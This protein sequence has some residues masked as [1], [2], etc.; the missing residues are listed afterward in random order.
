MSIS[1]HTSEESHEGTE[2]LLDIVLPEATPANEEHYE[3]ELPHDFDWR[4]HVGDPDLVPSELAEKLDEFSLR[5]SG[6]DE[7]SQEFRKLSAGLNGSDVHGLNKA[8]LLV[9]YFEH[10]MHTQDVS[11]L[12]GALHNAGV[13]H[14]Q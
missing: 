12:F 6:D 2:E 8:R 7:T 14:V 9:K 3:E 11:D 5:V 13:D 1:S 4:A 10:E